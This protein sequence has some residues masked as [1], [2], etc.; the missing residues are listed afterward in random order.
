MRIILLSFLLCASFLVAAQTVDSAAIRQV[1]SL[2]KISLDLTR[3]RDYEKSLE[4][5]ATA[6]KIALEN[7]GGVGGVWDL[8]LQP[9]NVLLSMRNAQEAEKYYLESKAIREK[10]FG[11][12]TSRYA[13]CLSNLAILYRGMGDYEKALSLALEFKAIRE[14]I[15]GKEHPDYAQSLNNLAILYREM[16]NYEKAEPLAL[17]ALAIREKCW[18]KSTPIMLEA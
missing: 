4:V 18:E 2:I 1:D 5:N 17:E 9:G 12:R 13:N 10:V 7:W 6:E 14:K 16:G 8:L 3:K 11:K 15:L